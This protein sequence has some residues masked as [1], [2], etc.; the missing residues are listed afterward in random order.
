MNAAGSLVQKTTT[1]SYPDTEKGPKCT[2]ELICRGTRICCCLAG[3]SQAVTIP[4]TRL[5]PTFNVIQYVTIDTH[6]DIKNTYHLHPI[7]HPLKFRS[8]ARG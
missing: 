1:E 3:Q 8:P 6:S 5:H 7:Q 4:E 2:L